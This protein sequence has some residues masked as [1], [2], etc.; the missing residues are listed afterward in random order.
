[1]VGFFLRLKIP[2]AHHLAISG[3]FYPNMVIWN[4]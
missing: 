2:V 4:F 1:L 3:A